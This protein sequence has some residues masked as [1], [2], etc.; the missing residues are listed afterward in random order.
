MSRKSDRSSELLEFNSLLSACLALTNQVSLSKWLTDTNI[1]NSIVDQ[2]NLL[3][4][5]EKRLNNVRDTIDTMRKYLSWL[6]DEQVGYSNL[7]ECN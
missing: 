2:D 6:E 1:V 4:E 7:Q 5:L 3:E